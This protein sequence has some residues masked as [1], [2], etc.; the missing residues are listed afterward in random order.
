MVRP[1]AGSPPGNISGWSLH[2]WHRGPRNLSIREPWLWLRLGHHV[3]FLL[4]CRALFTRIYRERNRLLVVS[5]Q[6]LAQILLP[7][8]WPNP[9]RHCTG[10]PCTEGLHP[11][12]VPR[13]LQVL[14]ACLE[15][16]C[17]P[18]MVSRSDARRQ[19]QICGTQGI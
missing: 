16:L 13:G 8:C 1:V 5:A 7:G 18:E 3:V 17:G 2:P 4:F 19:E 11:L 15:F 6:L 10:L 9:L 12:S 14:K